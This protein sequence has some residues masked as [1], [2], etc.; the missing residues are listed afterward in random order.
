MNLLD[1][2]NGDCESTIDV[3][4]KEPRVK[5]KKY[6]T[7]GYDYYD[8]KDALQN[9]CKAL[10]YNN[11]IIYGYKEDRSDSQTDYSDPASWDGIA[12]KNGYIL[13]MNRNFSGSISG[14]Y[15]IQS[16]VREATE[17]ID[18]L[19]KKN[20]KLL[21][22]ATNIAASDGE[23]TNANAMI[24]KNNKTIESYRS[25]YYIEE[26]GRN[27]F[28]ADLPNVEYQK[29]PA[30]SFWHIEKDGKILNKG[31]GYFK[32]CDVQNIDK[33]ISYSTISYE[34]LKDNSYEIISRNT[35]ESWKQQY[36][37]LL[38]NQDRQEGLLDD[39][40]DF[41]QVLETTVKLKLGEGEEEQLVR[42]VRTCKEV[43]YTAEITTDKT[44]YIT[45]GQKWRTISGLEKGNIYKIIDNIAYKLTRKMYSK[46]G[47]YLSSYKPIPNKSTKGIS[48]FALEERISENKL[49]Y[50]ELIEN[51]TTYEKEEW[52]KSSDKNTD[53]K[54]KIFKKPKS[55]NET[56]SEIDYEE[57]L[58][59]GEIKSDKNK[60]N[61][62]YYYVALVEKLELDVF[63]GLCTYLKT[64]NLGFY[65]NGK[66]Y[67]LNSLNKSIA[68]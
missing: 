46:N 10:A 67:Y 56:K 31:K 2:M 15:V 62:T 30:G 57:I 54:T 12:V 42:V 36:A 19:I 44:E 33:Y 51:S 1:F 27:P 14:N 43:Y 41:L 24:E 29:N 17:A 25:T 8:K 63:K 59:R 40:M 4:V 16:Y 23:K 45:V 48:I 47:N 50:V 39:F 53:T 55:E 13:V 64:N 7:R 9:I 6:E 49:S 35:E 58:N 3:K 60:K 61:N 65:I 32:F 66:G 18:K 11:W 28:P 38:R 5:N 21:K 37:Y 52:V 20:E 68:A 34:N 22:L 26:N